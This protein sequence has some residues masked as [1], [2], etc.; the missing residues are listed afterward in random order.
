MME[1]MNAITLQEFQNCSEQWKKWWNKCTDSQGEYFQGDYSLK[2][3]RE[4]YDLKKISHYFWAPHHR[5]FRGDSGEEGK[6]LLHQRAALTLTG[7]TMCK[8]IAV[9]DAAANK[10]LP[11]STHIGDSVREH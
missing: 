1:A 8:S 4:I 2:M 6:K 11:D 9:Q 3:L 5:Q 10:V 7:P